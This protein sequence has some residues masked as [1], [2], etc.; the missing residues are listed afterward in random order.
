MSPPEV[1]GDTA[2]P[3]HEASPMVTNRG[4]LSV[5]T[6]VPP[7]LQGFLR[8]VEL[9]SD[10]D[11]GFALMDVHHVESSW[12]IVDFE[13]SAYGFVLALHDDRRL[14]LQYVCVFSD[15]DTEELQILPMQEEHYPHLDGGSIVWNDDVADLNRFL[16]P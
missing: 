2:A 5:F 6:I 4:V 12:E 8:A 14:Y 3:P 11:R 15:D 13:S 10:D 9:A 1:H 16:A 7:I